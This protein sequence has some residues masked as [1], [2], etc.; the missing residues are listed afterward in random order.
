MPLLHQ[1]IDLFLHL[2]KH[3]AAFA[4]AHQTGV[5]I[6]LALI[7][8]CETGLV[9]WPFLPGDSLL[10]AVGALAGMANSPINL[11]GVIIL[12][13]ACANCGDILNYFVG[14]R[15]GPAIFSGESSWLLNKRHLQEA[16]LFYEKHGRK[17]IILARFVPIIRTFAPFVA[18][19]GQM[20]FPRFI[21][22]SISGG[23]LW[24]VLLTLA[25]YYFNQ[26]QFVS[27]H[28]QLVVL[29]IVAISL[30]PPVVQALSARKKSAFAPF[31]LA[32]GSAGGSST[33]Q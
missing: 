10:F 8:F 13:C 25:G 12:L 22:F 1:F 33:P 24:V 17:T 21:G 32:P 7:V 3:L 28:F 2:D 5:Y 23:V 20:P 16:H 9:I 30:I 29:A 18:G 27:T 4:S 31:P 11:L 19:I 26:I 14:R 6:L 15:I